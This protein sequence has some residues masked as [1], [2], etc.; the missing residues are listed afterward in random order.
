MSGDRSIVSRHV[1]TQRGRVGYLAAI[2]CILLH[3][4]P[5]LCHPAHVEMNPRLTIA[6]LRMRSIGCRVYVC[7]MRFFSGLA[8]FR[9]TYTKF[10]DTGAYCDA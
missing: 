5:V 6:L 7:G 1:A 2:P 10:G 3:F 9:P 4:L 8:S